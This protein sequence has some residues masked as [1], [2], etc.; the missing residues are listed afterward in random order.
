MNAEINMKELE[1]NIM[2]SNRKEKNVINSKDRVCRICYSGDTDE[3]NPLIHPC[4]CTGSLKYIHFNCLKYWIEQNII[5]LE[6]NYEF[7]QRYKYK[8]PICELCKSKYPGIIIHKGK[9]YNFLKE[10]NSYENYVAFE[11]LSCGELDD[12]NNKYKILYILS[13]DKE[14][15]IM[16]IGRSNEN[17]LFLK[18]SSIS[19]N[20]CKL[21]VID[22]NLF[23]EDMGSKYGTL[24]LIQTPTIQLVENLNLFLQIDNNLI[25]CKVY[26]PSLSSFFGCCSTINPDKPFDYYYKQNKIKSEEDNYLNNIYKETSDNESEQENKKEKKLVLLGFDGNKIKIERSKKSQTNNITTYANIIFPINNVARSY[27]ASVKED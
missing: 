9:E 23:I 18:E 10:N 5:I 27:P 4:S 15:Q 22:N 6:D 19:R 1:Q 25:I 8:E 3:E 12:N 13:L 7:F 20:H 17:D 2:T 21:R 14:N 16:Q 26:N 11:K 24:I